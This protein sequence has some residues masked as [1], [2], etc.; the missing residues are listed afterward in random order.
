[1]NNKPLLPAILLAAICSTAASSCG[2]HRETAAASTDLASDYSIIELPEAGGGSYVMPK[3]RIYRTS[4]S[5]DSLVP[6][7]LNPK[8]NF[9]TSY[10]APSDLT[11][12]PVRLTDGW[13]LDRRGIAPSTVFT[14]FTYSQYRAL[15]QTPSPEEI[16]RSIAPGITVTDIVELPMTF[17]AATPEKAD[18]LIR[19][20]LPGCKTI[21]KR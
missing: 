8:S 3:A 20:G 18:S 21:L 14:T 10:P 1:M 16:M 15:P 11:S 7:T 9:L 12:P 19:A 13:M 6:V 2:S 5:S 4:Q 17:N